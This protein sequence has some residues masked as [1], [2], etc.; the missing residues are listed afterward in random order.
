M[1]DVAFPAVLFVGNGVVAVLNAYA[2]V[3]SADTRDL[4]ASI[5]WAGSMAYW[6]VRLILEV[7]V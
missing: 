1:V 2:Y 3:K 7:C 5:V 6:L 4:V